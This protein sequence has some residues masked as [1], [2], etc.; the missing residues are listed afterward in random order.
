[1][2]LDGRDRPHDGED[3]LQPCPWPCRAASFVHDIQDRT[4]TA[5]Q[6]QQ[7]SLPWW[8]THQGGAAV[9]EAAR[10]EEGLEDVAAELN[11]SAAPD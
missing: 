4:R 11:L 1:M 10:P 6:A 7:R 2:K 9:P 8:P 3:Q 5:L